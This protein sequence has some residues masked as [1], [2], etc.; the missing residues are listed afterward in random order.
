[1]ARPSCTSAPHTGQ[2][3]SDV[4]PAQCHCVECRR[5]SQHTAPANAFAKRCR[6]PRR[7]LA[8]WRAS[9]RGR[10]SSSS[11][12]PIRYTSVQKLNQVFAEP[13]R[14][15]IVELEPQNLKAGEVCLRGA[16]ETRLRAG[17]QAP[18]GWG[19]VAAPI[20]WYSRRQR[21][22]AIFESMIRNTNAPLLC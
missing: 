20:D 13:F 4:S 14:W 3:T 12:A 2:P 9:A 16:P 5:T 11:Q 19:A 18:G 8:R 15:T 22:C 1:M 6:S 10:K 21:S 7:A 17:A